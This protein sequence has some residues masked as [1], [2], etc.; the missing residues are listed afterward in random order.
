MKMMSAAGFM[1]Y[2]TGYL[3][4]CFILLQFRQAVPSFRF[5][6]QSI[7]LREKNIVGPTGEINNA[8]A[9]LSSDGRTDVFR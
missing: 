8:Q 1:N 3:N 6:Q 7:H 5:R 2:L 4:C 9:L